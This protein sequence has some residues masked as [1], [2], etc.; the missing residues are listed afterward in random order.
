MS[1]SVIHFDFGI[2][3]T[4]SRTNK[5]SE[6]EKKYSILD[7]F[8]NYLVTHGAI[9]R[10]TCKVRKHCKEKLFGDYK[11]HLTALSN[12]L[13]CSLTDNVISSFLNSPPWRLQLSTTLSVCH[14]LR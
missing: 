4:D 10:D 13:K 9:P 2:L 11:S 8:T 5:V 7:K 12:S 6:F 1:M 14:Q 3:I